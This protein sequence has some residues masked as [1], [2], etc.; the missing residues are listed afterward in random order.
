MTQVESRHRALRSYQ[1]YLS[2]LERGQFNP[3]LNAMEVTAS[4][5]LLSSELWRRVEASQ[6]NGHSQWRRWLPARRAKFA[7]AE[8]G[9]PANSKAAAPNLRPGATEPLPRAARRPERDEGNP[10]TA[11]PQIAASRRAFVEWPAPPQIRSL[12]SSAMM[13]VELAGR[14]APASAAAFVRPWPCTS[15]ADCLHH[16]WMPPGDRQLFFRSSSGWYTNT[17][18]NTKGS[19][20]R[21][22]RACQKLWVQVAVHKHR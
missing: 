16:G 4:H 6:G 12:R 22:W 2:R 20:Q 13:C 19:F 17:T 18:Q 15:C 8:F 7:A 14:T 5:G 10:T 9:Y 3:T 1:T 11:C 21:S